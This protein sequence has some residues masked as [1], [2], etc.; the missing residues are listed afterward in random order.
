[1]GAGYLIVHKDHLLNV[2]G[3]NSG[4][5]MATL[6]VARFLAQ[7]GHKVYVAGWL[8]GLSES[9]VNIDGVTYIDCGV[10]Y[11]VQHAINVV[12]S[13]VP[14][15]H[16]IAAGRALPLLLLSE[17]PRCKTRVFISQDRAVT[18]SGVSAAVLNA[19]TDA[20]ICVS[21]AQASLFLQEG[22]ASEKVHVVHNGIDTALFRPGNIE[23]RDLN[24]IVF[25]GALV[26]DKG[27]QLLIPAYASLKQ[28]YP[29]LKLDVYGS[30]ALWGRKPFFDET[31]IA[32]QIPGITFHGA[33][34]Q[35][36]L[37]RSLSTAGFSVVP[38]IW[39]D[40]FPLVAME[41]QG[42]GCPVIG[43]AAG[44]IPEGIIHGETGLVVNDLTQ[45]GLERAM[46]SLL[47]DFGRLK[48]MS[49]AAS[50]HIHSNYTWDKFAGRVV[51][52]CNEG[53]KSVSSRTGLVTTWNEECGL[54]TYASYIAEASTAPFKIFA[55]G[56]PR[57]GDTKNVFRCWEKHANNYQ[58]LV[59]AVIAEK[60]EILLLNIQVRFFSYPEIIDCITALREHGVKVCALLHSTFTIDSECRQLVTA[61]DSVFVH[62][63]QSRLQIIA[64]GVEAEKV[65]IIQHGVAITEKAGDGTIR[66][67]K[68][69]MRLPRNEELILSFGFIQPHKGMEVIIEA[70]QHL[71]AKGRPV[72]GIIAGSTRADDPGSQ[73]YLCFLKNQ[74][75]ASG[76]TD[77]ITIL[78]GFMDQKDLQLIM[79]ASDC[80]VMNYQSQYF[81]ASG[82]CSLAIASGTPVVTSAA[83]PFQAFGDAVWQCTA[84]YPPAMAI[85]LVLSSPILR[86]EL[87]RRAAD[88]AS[89]NSWTRISQQLSDMM[90]KVP[91]THT[92]SGGLQRRE[93]KMKQSTSGRIRVL[94]QNRTNAY[95]QPGGDTRV[96]DALA[97]G[98]RNAGLIV[99]IDCE[100]KVNPSNYDLV[101]L[102]NFATPAITEH[103]ARVAHAAGVPY[104]VTTLCE[105][106]PSFHNQ[107]HA[108]SSLLMEYVRNGQ[109][110]GWFEQAIATMSPAHRSSRFQNDWT[111]EHA[112]KLLS[113]GKRES[114]V[115]QRDY[116]A[117]S[118]SKFEIVELASPFSVIEDPSLFTDTYGV[119]DFVLS[120]GRLESRK[121]QLMLLKALEDSDLPVV[122]ATGGFSYQPEY[123]E[124]VRKF[125]RRGTTIICD[126]L[127]DEMLASA[128]A[129][130]RV[131]VLCS[132]FELPGL[133][134]LE[135]AAR[136]CNVVVTRNGTASDY[137]QDSAFYTSPEDPASIRNS[138]LAAF[139][140]PFKSELQEV[141]SRYTWEQTTEQT[142]EVYRSIPGVEKA[143]TIT[144]ANEPVAAPLTAA[145][146]A[147]GF[148]ST[149]SGTTGSFDASDSVNEYQELLERGE[150][151]AREREFGLA[152]SYLQRA[153]QLNPR[154]FRVI[155]ARGAVAF[156]QGNTADAARLFE[157]ALEIDPENPRGLSG[158]GMCEMARKQPEKAY[159]RFVQALDRD[160]AHAATMLQL[161]E[162]SYILNRFDDLTRLLKTYTE[163]FPEDVDM[164]YCYAGALFKTG[165]INEAKSHM[166]WVLEQKPDHKGANEL[167]ARLQS[168]N[169]EEPVRPVQTEVVQN[170][171]SNQPGDFGNLVNRLEQ[172]AA[173]LTSVFSSEGGSVSDKPAIADE[174]K[175]MEVLKKK[176]DYSTMTE[177]CQKLLHRSELTPDQRDQVEL[178]LAEAGVLQGSLKSS[179]LVFDRV[180]HRNQAH[181]RALCGKGALE[182]HRGNWELAERLFKSAYEIDNSYDVALAGLGMVAASKGRNENAWEHYLQALQY[183]PENTRALLGI[184]ELGYTMNR[185]TEL[186]QVLRKFLD[187][188][189]EQTDYRY[190][191]AG[192][193][194]AQGMY[195][196][197]LKQLQQVLGKAPSDARALELKQHIEQE[198]M[199]LT[200]PR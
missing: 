103:Y 17:S 141:A 169:V 155:K 19:N 82:A 104:V 91:F 164:R 130:A 53:E 37:A 171:P 170:V 146:P 182:C 157:R 35:E 75:E 51:E 73:Q 186:E 149:I 115:L 49:G 111:V 80:I 64:H 70:V 136:G 98:L 151:A 71:R 93:I 140:S 15:F 112:A 125:R 198:M 5:E 174:I 124:A 176:R 3:V 126:R 195:D 107:S 184:I 84:G 39:F 41:A 143:E 196:A 72:H 108:Y 28:K 88:Y 36:E 54:A 61:V 43:F 24:R 57:E 7:Q 132:W 4:A 159:D 116:P 194:Y 150:H 45:E 26:P 95:S 133:V 102:F 199:D 42:A 165:K 187:R 44:G 92:L 138:V 74:I 128:Y 87:Q 12:E 38:S 60:I 29:D 148:E 56:A 2:T 55:P 109:P 58:S 193:L 105:D 166:Q 23:D 181:P 16:C 83:P 14:Y 101:H 179:E 86:S 50:N 21:K 47:S 173:K 168:M 11:N 119:K 22:F 96:M 197:A 153:E 46:D 188:Q 18:D 191:L 27:I 162:C 114:T 66:L 145:K 32:R 127:S 185:L 147:S 85:E 160:I 177:E 183:N 135:A 122:L 167:A 139:Y 48:Q 172:T 20:V 156:A 79:Q 134:S 67:H 161:I 118:P 137:F 99:D 129:A 30:A 100:G 90:S 10:S 189:P 142:I 34:K 33:V 180:L 62:S 175:R 158:M 81:E 13:E 6:S 144:V 40:P 65:S 8:G 110:A 200:T 106:V 120:V 113:T 76:L 59:D 178:L 78:E 25:S 69:R 152:D 77:H 117:C 123:A 89:N 68:A 192:C 97:D 31:E 52:L 1:M 154:S 63:P 163:K 94:F 131:H 190:S 121:N 9:P